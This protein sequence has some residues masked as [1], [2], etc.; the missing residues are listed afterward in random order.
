MVPGRALRA[1]ALSSEA[2]HMSGL[3]AGET[4]LVHGSTG[5]VGLAA[6]G[7]ISAAMYWAN[8]DDPR[9]VFLHSLILLALSGLALFHPSLF[10]LTN[11][12]GGGSATRAIHPW[13]GVILFFSFCGLFFRFVRLNLPTSEDA[14]WV[15]HLPDVL[16]GNEENLPE[17]GKYNAGQKLMFW[18]MVGSVALLLISGSPAIADHHGE[19][20]TRVGTCADA[21]KQQDYFCDQKNAASDSMVALGTAC[22]NAKINARW[23]NSGIMAAVLAAR[24]PGWPLAAERKRPRVAC[25]SRRVWRAL[26]AR[27]RYRP[28]PACRSRRSPALRGR[29]PGGC[30]CTS[31]VLP[32]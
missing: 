25:S 9:V 27:R 3:R 28:C 10:W 23:P 7:T 1:T 29:G 20:K 26:R 8:I 18:T 21:K 22:R 14:A 16:K 15:K 13:I 31:P 24:L 32:S 2:V 4:L 11:L 12:F 6:A 19:K 17:I 30:R 5:A